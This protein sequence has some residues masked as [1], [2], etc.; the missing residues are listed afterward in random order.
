M[1]RTIDKKILLKPLELLNRTLFQ[2]IRKRSLLQ[3]HIES[4]NLINKIS[5][6]KQGNGEYEP[7]RTVCPSWFSV[8]VT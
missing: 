8:M 1:G 5:S 7:A 3:V 6:T 2:E 4:N